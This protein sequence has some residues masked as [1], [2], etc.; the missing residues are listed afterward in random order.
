MTPYEPRGFWEQRLREQF[1]LRG[2]GEIGMSVAYNRACYALRL[3]VLERALRD[4][5]MD[6]SGR[7][8]LDVGCGT[9]FFT[10]YYLR[11]GAQVTGIDIAPASI[12]R[13]RERFPGASF[14]EADV[15]Q[16]TL[17]GT[18]DLVNS[19]D[20]FFHIVDDARWEAALRNVCGA[21]AA[22]GM[23]VYTDV[24][25]AGNGLAEHN[26]TR[27][28]ERH[29]AVLEANRMEVVSLRPTHV[30]LNRPLGVFRFLNRWP[31]LLYA[32]DRALLNAGVGPGPAGNQLL[33]ARRRHSR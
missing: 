26:R 22:G 19:F 6:P 29:R 15:S 20:V 25:V 31:G 2:T 24:F 9:G 1:D 33:V 32:A 11:R 18:Y 3:R 27:P 10:E 23:L 17:L 14:V 7:R 8:V 21:L 12:A 28:L 4:A 30:L 16:T 13:M 5:G